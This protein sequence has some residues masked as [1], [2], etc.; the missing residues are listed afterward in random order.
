MARR[1]LLIAGV[2]SALVGFLAGLG[3]LALPWVR[4]SVTASSLPGGLAFDTT[5]TLSLLNLARG[6]WYLALLLA[7]C[8]ALAAAA[9]GRGLLHRLGG[10]VGV[11]LGI[12][13]TLLAVAIVN[14]VSAG[15]VNTSVEG[16][17]SIDASAS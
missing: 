10:V 14:D 17:L 15:A 9:G 6:A 2:G 13:G 16:L 7:T 3:A 12:A 1:V 4:Y 5:G 8:A 11:L